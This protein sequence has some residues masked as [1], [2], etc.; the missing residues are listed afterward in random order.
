MNDI[1]KEIEIL[2]KIIEKSIDHGAGMCGWFAEG[3]SLK[4]FMDDYLTLKGL[5]DKY[6]VDNPEWIK[7]MPGYKGFETDTYMCFCK[8]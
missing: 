1:E 3:E 6:Y 2:N 8:R 5:H 4:A 7:S